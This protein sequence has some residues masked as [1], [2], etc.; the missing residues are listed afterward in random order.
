MRPSSTHAEGTRPRLRRLANLVGGW[1]LVVVGLILVPLPGPGWL[2]V[3]IGLL[4]LSREV[5]WARGALVRLER[6]MRRHG[7]RTS[8]H[9]LIARRRRE[10]RRRANPSAQPMD[11]V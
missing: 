2:V 3:G 8:L 7:L 6:F 9:R 11:L 10:R 5:R 4:V 1:A